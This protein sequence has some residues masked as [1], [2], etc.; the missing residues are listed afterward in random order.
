MKKIFEVMIYEKFYDVYSIEDK[1]HESLNGEPD[2]WWLYLGQRLPEGEQPTIDSP[3]WKPWNNNIQRCIWEIRLKQRNTTKEKWDETRF[4]SSTNVEIYCNG[5]LFYSFSTL[6]GDSGMAFAMAKAQYMIVKMTEHPFN[7]LEPEKENGRQIW[8]YNLPA[9]VVVS[10]YNPWE[11]R[12]K[13]DYSTGL[14]KE[15]WWVEY[16]NRQNKVLSAQE[17][18]I[19]EDGFDDEDNDINEDLINWGDALSDGNIW[20]FRK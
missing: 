1:K 11:I 15:E 16:K 5:K 6:G 18:F 2:T 14:T 4:S 9:T 10:T 12:I 13:P 20:W 19:D 7:F 3:N 8:W 17:I